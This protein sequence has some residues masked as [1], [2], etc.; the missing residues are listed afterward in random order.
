MDLIPV[1]RIS[2][3]GR[4]AAR[5][6][7]DRQYFVKKTIEDIYKSALQAAERETT[8]YK[9]STGLVRKGSTSQ[10]NDYHATM[11]FD[12]SNE[13]IEELRKL[14]PECTV[15]YIFRIQDSA[16]IWHEV[17]TMTEALKLITTY[18]REDIILID[19]A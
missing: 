4:R 16:G 13:I 17:S 15:K 11:L 10:H 19:W 2:M 9:Y 6:E 18:Y 14:F 5:I 3:Q 12:N 8:T 1:S 7:A